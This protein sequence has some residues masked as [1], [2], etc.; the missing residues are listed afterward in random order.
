MDGRGSALP[1]PPLIFGGPSR[2]VSAGVKVNKSRWDCYLRRHHAPWHSTTWRL[3]TPRLDHRELIF[4][5]IVAQVTN[6]CRLRGPSAISYTGVLPLTPKNTALALHPNLHIIFEGQPAPPLI[7][8]S[9]SVGRD[10]AWQKQRHNLDAARPRQRKT[11][12]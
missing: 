2:R 5:R 3:T 12:S 11:C 8:Y 9:L 4:D 1:T 6:K 10:M 7:S